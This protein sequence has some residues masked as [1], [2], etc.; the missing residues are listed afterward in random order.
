MQQ[1][2]GKIKINLCHCKWG[3]SNLLKKIA[4]ACSPAMTKRKY[5][6]YAMMALCFIGVI[7]VFAPKV[8]AADDHIDDHIVINEIYPNPNSG[9]NEWIEFYNPT[10]ADIDLSAYT[11]EDG[12]HKPKTLAGK[13]IP[14]LS[15]FVIEKTAGGFSFALNDDGEI[16]ILKNAGIVVDQVVYGKWDDETNNPDNN[17]PVPAQGKSLSRI[18]NGSDSDN[19][20]S[21][22]RILAPTKDL[23]NVL[24]VY[25]NSII[26]NEILP[27]PASGSADEFIELYNSGSVE[28]DLSGWQ[29][30]DIASGG[31]SP[32]TVPVGTIIIAGGYLSF[33]NTVDHISLNDSGDSARLIDPNGDVKSEIS[34]GKSNR[35]QS[36]SKF[37]DNWQWTTALTP[38]GENILT[39]EIQTP[40]QDATI[41]TTDISGARSQPDGETVQVTGVVSVTPGKLS[42]QY[43]YIQDGNS[44]IQIYNYGKNFP[45][46]Q[47]GD[48]IQVV[49]ELGS[50]SN[51]RRIKITQASDITIISTHPPP[52]PLSTVI[53]QVGENLEGQ[54]ISVIGVVT[55]TSGSTFYIHGSGEIQITIRDGTG[56]KKPKMR[57]GDTVQIAGIL[58]QYGDSYRILPISQDDVKIIKSSKLADSGSQAWLYFALAAI[59]T[60]LWSIF[61]KVYQRRKN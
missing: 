32:Y 6:L 31:S 10:S 55:K 47:V 13:T 45:A 21:D 25:S 7:F 58:S 34:Y 27:Q 33:Y 43:F 18:P 17:A 42:S 16:L 56:I 30:D 22:F 28:V 52:A 51:E 9:G 2:W 5:I 1:R 48:E 61:Q 11:I 44:G 24:P 4:T 38:G 37:G 20:K 60:I 26:I 40:D 12:T 39:V 53:D 57:V 19:D 15:Y 3:Q 59:S 36:Y 14:A 49:G 50:T 29:I 23:E 35:G 8:K 54:Y 46:L 41:L